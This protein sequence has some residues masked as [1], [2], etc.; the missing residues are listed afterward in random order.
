MEKFEIYEGEEYKIVN[1]KDYVLNNLDGLFTG[2]KVANVK[3]EKGYV[4]QE[5]ETV[6]KNGMVE[7]KNIVSYD[8]ETGEPDWIIT[9]AT[10]EKM[11]ITDS[12]FK[13]LYNKVNTKEGEVLTPVP[14]DRPLIRLKENIAIMAPWGEMQ[15]IK[16]GGVLA[17]IAS[18]DIYG[19]QEYEFDKSYKTTNGDAKKLLEENLKIVKDFNKPKIFLS[20]S[21]PHESKED[22]K[23]MKE[24][25]RYVNSKG[26][27]AINVKKLKENNINL[28]REISLVLEK[29]QGVLSIAFD[30]NNGHTSPFVHIETSLASMLGLN[31]LMLLP[32]N[33]VSEGILFDDNLDGKLKRIDTTKSLYAP[34]NEEVLKAIDKFI[35]EIIKRYTLNLKDQDLAKFKQ[36]L[37]ENTNETKTKLK[38][39][40]KAFYKLE[41]IDFEI[42]DI[43]VKRPTQIKAVCI[44][45]DGVYETKD[46]RVELKKGDFLV[47][48]KNSTVKPY[49]V[50]QEQFNL[51]YMK[52]N[53]EEDTYVSK[54]TPVIK[55]I[56]NG[57]IEVMPLV[58]LTDKYNIDISD[59][60]N[61]YTSIFSHIKNIGY[62]NNTENINDLSL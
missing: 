49:A 52:V 21:Y 10:G 18:N 4:G 27:Q 9:Q 37:I 12:N 13:N 15:Y 31:N 44:D 35:S 58:D 40:L 1:G 19:I 48:N 6:M 50:K 3:A 20:V 57:K 41:D 23:F 56:K 25:I 38:K 30:R 26:I 16:K 47:L 34:E 29:C 39:F 43:Y 54:L 11:I 36:G 24:V 17:V 51:R 14:L 59:F 7:T 28:I 5:V 53:G 22:Q 33:V 60:E 62:E 61:S 46:G 8:A 42:S 32:K 55:T 2:I 45:K